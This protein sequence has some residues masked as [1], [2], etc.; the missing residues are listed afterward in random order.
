MTNNGK[1]YNIVVMKADDLP[2]MF[3]TT[4]DD[5]SLVHQDKELKMPGK[6]MLAEKGEATAQYDGA[7]DHIKGR[8]NTSW[9]LDKK[10]YNIKLPSASSLLGMDSSKKWSLLAVHSEP[11]V[12][13]HKSCMILQA[14]SACNIRR[15]Q[16]ILTW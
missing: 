8:G 7:L 6:M 1:R 3:I 4:E 2:A 14:K 11:T 16:N 9:T 5:L 15:I 12:F 10:P 13:R